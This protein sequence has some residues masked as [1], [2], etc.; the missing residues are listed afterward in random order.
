MIALLA[1]ALSALAFFGDL[2][3]QIDLL[4]QF[5]FQAG[6]ALAALLVL[7][8]LWRAR[9]AVAFSA[10]GI[11]LNLYALLVVPVAATPSADAP[12]MRVVAYNLLGNN[13]PIDD[14]VAWLREGKF[15]VVSFEELTPVFAARLDA[16]A[17][18]YPYRLMEPRKGGFG[19][20]LISRHPFS[21]QE[22][23]F[24]ASP[25]FPALRVKLALGDAIVEIVALHPPPP[26]GQPL[27]AAHD[28]ILAMLATRLKPDPR[29]I[30]MG[31]FNAAPT[32]F[33]LRRFCAALDLAGAGRMPNL[34]W[35]TDYPWPLRIPI[36][37]IFV[38]SGL[39]LDKLTS[40]PAMG[41]D[42]FPQ[43]A[44]VMLRF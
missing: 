32:S 35:P 29:R 15:D 37:H 31:D 36:D 17:D 23:M 8:L 7:A 12:F 39:T 33:A 40:G 22:I 9:L 38:G 1:A 18:V 30:V 13:R 3:W 42:H 11:A 41:S 34:S 10:L 43:I 21:E 14:V 20:G 28:A 5:R 26:L 19:I 27:A 24:P 44:D 25:T 6:L 2:A 4:A 16:L